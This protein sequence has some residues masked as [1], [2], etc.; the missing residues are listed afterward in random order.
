MK[1]L[2]ILTFLIAFTSLSFAKPVSEATAK[3]VA[4]NF[5][6]NQFPDIQGDFTLAYEAYLP[7]S[8]ALTTIP[9]AASFYVFNVEDKGFV[10]VSG[11]DRTIP[12]LAFSNEKGFVSKNL[13]PEVGYMLD[14]YTNKI[15]Y[16]VK[17]NISATQ[18]ISAEWDGLINNTMPQ[19]K[20]DATSVHPMFNTM[21]NQFPYYNNDCPFNYSDA[22]R[23]V[24][25]CVATAMAQVMKYWNWP[26]AGT[27][28]NSYLTADYGLLSANFGATTYDWDSMPV[29]L[30][31]YNNSSSIATL[32]YD[33]GIAVDMSYG[34]ASADGSGAWVIY[35]NNGNT[36]FCAENALKN[37]FGYS[38]GI[39]GYQR[40]NYSDGTWLALL[41]AEINGGRPII[42]SGYEPQSAGGG[43]HC[44]DFDGYIINSINTY[45][46]VNWGWG[47]YDDGNF[48]I[49]MLNPGT[50]GAGAG[51]GTFD[52]YEEAIMGI[53]P[54]PSYFTTGIENIPS[55]GN[56]NIYPNP[57]KGYTI[58]N[59]SGFN[60][61]AQQLNLLSMDGRVVYSTTVEN[62][63]NIEI[64]TSNITDGVYI[65]QIL[66]DKGILNSKLVVTK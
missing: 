7:K 28:K 22:E 23:T 2:L 31:E 8:G 14:N 50:G 59:L 26:V 39:E 25:G 61:V 42:Y 33:C 24:T 57:A 18:T 47:G 46:H 36:K 10:I 17:N 5:L 20:T 48:T 65:V 27:G 53:Q 30:T 66:T 64:N 11:D 56:V 37:N 35:P 58:A 62:N 15:D 16:I 19:P 54:P 51:S 29:Q 52:L 44:F 60:G 21:W 43:G 9:Q 6:A 32:M 3:T 38:T 41:V 34:V 13:S 63:N 40:V 1:R 55:A 45:F 49:D 4:Q 12:I